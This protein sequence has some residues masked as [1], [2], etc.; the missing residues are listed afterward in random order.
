MPTSFDLERLARD[1]EIVGRRS[2]LR[3]IHA[4]LVTG[5]HPLLEG[6]VGVGKTALARAVAE[7]MGRGFVRID[8]DGR[9]TEAKLVGHYDPPGVLERGYHPDLFIAGPLVRAMRDG[10]LLFI[11]ELN[12]MPEGVQNVLLPALDEGMVLVPHYG[13]VEA[14][15]GFGLVATQNPAEF[16]ATGHLSEALLDRFELVQLD[17]QDENEER[18]IVQQEARFAPTTA[19]VA[20]A[21]SVVRATRCDPRIRRG[22]S[23]RAA[24]AI[25]DLTTALDGD[26]VAATQLALPTRIELADPRRTPASEVLR[27]LLEQIEKKKPGILARP[28]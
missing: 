10:A 19:L 6:P 15:A 9:Y 25:A 4:C 7:G 22:A 24:I 1:H 27:D 14:M 23:I 26:I 12:R 13:R 5:R 21:V 16:V 18:R 3:A 8:G 28:R 17:Y 11:N 2:Q 20:H